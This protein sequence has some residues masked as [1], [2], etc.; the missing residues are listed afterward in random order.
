MDLKNETCRRFARQINDEIAAGQHHDPV[1][2]KELDRQRITPAAKQLL[3]IPA[4]SPCTLYDLVKGCVDVLP[5]LRSI[6]LLSLLEAFGKEYIAEREGISLDDVPGRVSTQQPK[7]HK[8]N[9]GPRAS[10]SFLNTRYL[11]FLLS[12]LYGVTFTGAAID[13]SFWEAGTV[14]NCL[15]HHNGA[16]PSEEVRLAL[17]ATILT[18]GIQDAVGSRLVIPPSLVWQYIK[19]TRAF[20]KVCDY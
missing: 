17:R 8:Q 12:D 15:V 18:I 11:A 1:L 6:Y 5:K 10:T 4:D 20:L 9:R 19:S 14:R 7:W 16:I 3:G 2:V 13:P